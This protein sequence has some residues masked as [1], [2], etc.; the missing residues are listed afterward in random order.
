[1]KIYHGSKIIIEEPKQKGSNPEND[2]GPAF[3][4]TTDL[5]MAKKNLKLIM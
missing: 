2:Y 3:Y 1:M 5:E 4:V